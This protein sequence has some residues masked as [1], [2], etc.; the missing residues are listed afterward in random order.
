M[1]ICTKKISLSLNYLFSKWGVIGGQSGETEGN[2]YD[3]RKEG[4]DSL[5]IQMKIR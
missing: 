1:L 5:Q 2:F 3:G 4:I